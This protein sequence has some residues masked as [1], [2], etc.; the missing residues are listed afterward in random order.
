MPVDSVTGTQVTFNL[1][2]Y[3]SFASYNLT[4]VEIKYFLLFPKGLTNILCLTQVRVR[5]IQEDKSNFDL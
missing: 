2:F 5:E 3:T 1:V 4:L